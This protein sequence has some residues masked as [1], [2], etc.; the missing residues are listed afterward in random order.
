MGQAWSFA[1]INDVHIGCYYPEYGGVGFADGDAG[2]EYSLTQRLR[3]TV[4]WINNN[5]PGRAIRFVALNGDLTDSA[6]ESEFLK[7]KKILDALAIPYVPLFGNHDAWPYTCKMTSTG[8]TGSDVFNRIFKD[9]FEGLA[10]SPVVT[11]WEKDTGKVADTPLNNYSFKVEGMCFIALDLVSRDAAPGGW[12]VNGGA[13]LH[14]GTRQWLIDHLGSSGDAPVVLLSHHPL[15]NQLR[16]PEGL[17]SPEWAVIKKALAA[18]MPSDADCK[19]IANLLEGHGNVRAAFAGHIHS[20]ELLIGHTPTPP[21]IWDFDDIRFKP[22]RDVDVR[23]T[24]AVSAGSNGPAGEDKGTVRIAQVT[25]DGGVDYDTVAGPESPACNHAINPSFDVNNLQGPFMFV[26]HRFTKQPVEFQF[27]YG[28]GATSG[29]FK[30]LD[31]PWW[32]RVNLSDSVFHEYGDGL[33]FHEVR[34]RMREKIGGGA[35]FQEEITRKV[36]A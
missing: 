3:D 7:V 27:D 14:A 19:E 12:G 34:L 36:T 15:G 25:G 21:F 29:D 8:P 1:L 10:A 24:E 32:D 23:L 11:G 13:V 33:P 6:E 4:T 9:T 26:P 30:P 17:G 16:K 31:A 5:G 20:A 2:Q 18:G 28:D 22:I 35:Y